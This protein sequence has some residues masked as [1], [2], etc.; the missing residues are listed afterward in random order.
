MKKTK[1]PKN[2]DIV[3][4]LLNRIFVDNYE[5]DHSY[6]KELRRLTKKHKR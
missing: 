5:V 1:A 6:D 2:N 3:T 4:E